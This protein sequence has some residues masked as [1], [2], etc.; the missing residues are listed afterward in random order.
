[1]YYV[2]ILSNQWHT[3][4]YTGMTNDIRRRL[5]EH[6]NKLFRHAFTRRFNCNQL[7]YY[8]RRNSFDDAIRREQDVKR[9]DRPYKMQLIKTINP[10][11]V[12]LAADWF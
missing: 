10:K 9:L 4:F 12:D 1:M 2:Y 5:F 11:M 7:L 8:E 3:V 6:K